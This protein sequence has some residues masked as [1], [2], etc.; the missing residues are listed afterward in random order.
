MKSEINHKIYKEKV[1][2]RE[3]GVL[4]SNKSTTCQYI[5]I[6]PANPENPIKYVRKVFILIMMTLVMEC[7][8]TLLQEVN[9]M[10]T[11]KVVLKVFEI[12]LILV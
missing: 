11:V 4:I 7:K 2:R 12:S 6:T 8:V 1:T 5:I 3:I 9:N 10:E